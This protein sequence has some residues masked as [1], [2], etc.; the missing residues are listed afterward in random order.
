MSG[1]VKVA[2][3]VVGVIVALFLLFLLFEVVLPNV[4]PNAF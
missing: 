1:P 2:A 4:F 3:W